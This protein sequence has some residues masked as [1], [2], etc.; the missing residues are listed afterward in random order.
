VAP[1]NEKVSMEQRACHGIPGITAHRAVHVGGDVRG[2]TVLV[3]GAAG[4]VGLCALALTRHA[5]AR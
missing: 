4:S 3:R 2:R 1:V 5:G